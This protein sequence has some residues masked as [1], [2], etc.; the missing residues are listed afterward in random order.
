LVMPL[1]PHLTEGVFDPSAI[2][3]MIAAF[4]AVCLSLQL[5]DRDD[6]LT[7]LVA[8]KVIEIAGTGERDP[9]R[10]CA[11]VLAALEGDRRTA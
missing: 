4:K 10:L 8:Q 7:Q 5:A 3:A 6:P 2:E 9:E 1:T 11:L